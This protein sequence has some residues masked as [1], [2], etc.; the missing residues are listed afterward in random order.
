MDRVG[1]VSVK[2]QIN[3]DKD[4]D[5]EARTLVVQPLGREQVLHFEGAFTKQTK[6]DLPGSFIPGDVT[7]IVSPSALGRA[8]DGLEGLVDYPYG[9]VEQTMSRFLPAVVVNAAA[10][11]LPIPL[12]PAVVAK[13]P[14]VL[15]KGLQRLYAFQHAD[16]GWGWWEHDNTDHRMSIYVV[17]GLA[18]CRASGTAVNAIVLER[19]GS[20]LHKEIAEGRIPA[21][22]LSLAWHAVALSGHADQAGLKKAAAT[23]LGDSGNMEDRCRLAL[24]CRTVG[25][26]ELAADLWKRC[27]KWQPETTEPIALQITARMIFGD[28]IPGSQT[29][30]DRMLKLRRGLGWE[31]TQ[32]TATAITALVRFLPHLPRAETHPKNVRI[33]IDDK[34]LGAIA[35]DPAKNQQVY[36]F[37]ATGERLTRK[38]GQKIRIEAD[39]DATLSYTIVAN[40]VAQLDKYEPTGTSLRMTRKLETLDG[41]PLAGALTIGQVV[42]VRVTVEADVVREYV[43]LEDRRPGNCEFADDRLEQSK[44]TPKPSHIEFRDDRLCVFFK[45]LPAGKHE[46]VYYL[47]G[48]TP[49]SGRQLPGCI[50][51]MY[52]D[53]IRGETGVDLVNVKNLDRK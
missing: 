43:L 24:A 14:D 53:Q 52:Q 30:A 42:Q 40:G 7:I 50:Y 18:L 45:K 48:E 44:Q 27:A 2:L 12:P 17:H 28:D 22:L 6:I 51:Q 25:L 49:G 46:F 11:E 38:L 36:R 16:G 33:F 41:K 10:K 5:A 1:T 3:A 19:G 8:L 47:R 35:D 15:A 4:A 9:C 32:A 20:H 26:K 39:G 13:L 23:A 37:H 31:N 34:L 29:V 21:P